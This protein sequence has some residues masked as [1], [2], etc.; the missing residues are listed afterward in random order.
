M[1]ICWIYPSI[2]ALP[3]ASEVR[4]CY[5]SIEKKNVCIQECS[6][7]KP[8]RWQVSKFLPSNLTFI[9]SF[10]PSSPNA[11]LNSLSCNRK[12]RKIYA[13]K[14]CLLIAPNSLLEFSWLLRQDSNWS[15]NATISH[16]VRCGSKIFAYLSCEKRLSPRLLYFKNL[17]WWFFSLFE[18]HL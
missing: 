12:T 8:G 15:V 3:A 5:L 2:Q 13:S 11:C 10:S 9:L 18:M 4:K 17:R 7:S 16:D 14:A 1:R 6:G